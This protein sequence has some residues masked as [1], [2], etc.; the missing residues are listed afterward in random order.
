MNDLGHAWPVS[1]LCLGYPFM[2]PAADLVSSQ[3]DGERL[4]A[5]AKV[6]NPDESHGVSY[7]RRAFRQIYLYLCDYNQ[8]VGY[9]VIFNTSA[10]FLRFSLSVPSEPLPRISFNQKTIFF[11]IVD[12]F[13]HTEPASRRPVAEA[14][15]L[16]ENEILGEL[17][18]ARGDC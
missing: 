9:L 17:S 1:I 14:I 16:S 6:F 10:K 3:T 7:L 5:D 15:E 4:I 8:P 13:H 2:T 11:V 18:A 12:I